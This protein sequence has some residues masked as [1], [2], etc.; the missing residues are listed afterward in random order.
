MSGWPRSGKRGASEAVGT[1]VS[2]QTADEVYTGPI[3]SSFEWS[4]DHGIEQWEEGP[5]KVRLQ[6]L[7][8]LWVQVRNDLKQKIKHPNI[9][10][11]IVDIL[12]A[13][14]RF[15]ATT[16]LY[17]WNGYKYLM[18]CIPYLKVLVE[19][20]W[21]AMGQRYT[22]GVAKEVEQILI[23][24]SYLSDPLLLNA[25]R[26]YIPFANGY[27]HIASHK[28]V[29]PDPDL[30][31]TY[32]FEF[33]YVSGLDCPHFR[34]FIAD[35][36]SPEN[37]RK[38]CLYL[39][40]CLTNSIALQ[41]GQI[42]YGDGSNGKSV[43]M[44]LIN[45]LWRG[46]CS[47]VPIQQ[48]DEGF[49]KIALRGM[50]INCNAD[51]P[52]NRLTDEGAA[53]ECITDTDL[54]GEEK[55]YPRAKWKNITK[56]IYGCNKI[57][58][59]PKSATDAFFR[60]WEIIPFFQIFKNK[61]DPDFDPAVHKVAAN[62]DEFVERLQAEASGIMSYLITFLPDIDELRITDIARIRREWN[63]HSENTLQFMMECELEDMDAES[64]C[65]DLY[66]T[67]IKWCHEKKL[68]AQSAK[69]FGHILADNGIQREYIQRDG[70]RQYY[71]IG[72]KP[73]NIVQMTLDTSPVPPP[74]THESI[75][76]QY[77]ERVMNV[78]DA[79]FVSGYGSITITDVY[80]SCA[81]WDD[82]TEMICEEIIRDVAF[83]KTR[84]VLDGL[85]IYPVRK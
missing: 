1:E 70:V 71:Y 52:N 20:V 4:I 75:K 18:D 55:Y 16:R 62:K 14:N 68:H 72:I 32:A 60:R 63:M 25:N 65:G 10:S 58:L 61:I 83:H 29:S 28:L 3:A 54:E 48:L 74:K 22:D 66:R 34:Q 41:K 15:I 44:Q 82:M 69:M 26:H 5:I 33:S 9:N 42:W 36:V 77:K 27:Y 11:E 37:G 80:E 49:N 21:R 39:A 57:P 40:Y 7:I 30:F 59:P 43:L 46:L 76:A 6:P 78:M 64:G 2:D 51:L 45:Y 73:K 67:Y 50:L 23:N 8:G 13:S 84:Y 81:L 53:K 56:H 17:V 47:G 38:I 35:V 12:W 79:F 19:R 85:K 24:R 31:F